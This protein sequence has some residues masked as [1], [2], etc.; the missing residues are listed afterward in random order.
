MNAPIRDA[1]VAVRTETRTETIATV[2]CGNCQ[3]EF[4]TAPWFK[5]ARCQ[6]C[7]RVCR[8]DLADRAPEALPADVTPI[9]RPRRSA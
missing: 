9:R 2:R 4:D 3:F 1:I 5:T 6:R 8:L 7:R